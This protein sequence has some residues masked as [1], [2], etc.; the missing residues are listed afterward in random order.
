MIR[1]LFKQKK[2]S[3][4][5]FCLITDGA[6]AGL[7]P[8]SAGFSHYTSPQLYSDREDSRHWTTLT[9]TVQLALVF[10]ADLLYSWIC[11]SCHL[12]C[13]RR[14]YG[15]IMS[16]G[17]P[18]ACVGLKALNSFHDCTDVCCVLHWLRYGNQML[19]ELW[20]SKLNMWRSD[21]CM[22]LF[23]SNTL[24]LWSSDDL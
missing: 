24:S 6:G 18:V 20:H 14:G 11:C 15:Q 23:H 4:K 13:W 9:I 22:T 16:S 10:T 21:A 3:L 19:L 2:R 17:W 5:R 1:F 8:E 7:D 12:L